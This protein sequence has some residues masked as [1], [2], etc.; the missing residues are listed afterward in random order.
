MTKVLLLVF[1]ASAGFAQTPIPDHGGYWVHD[2]AH[3]LSR[4]TK[5][6]LEAAFKAE[7][8]STSNQIAVIT[9][10]SLENDDISNYA[11]NVFQK[12]KI[13]Q[14]KKDNGVLFVIAPN[15]RKVRIEVGYGLE[16][17]LT[18][19]LSSRIIRN[20]VAPFFRSDNFDAGVKAGALSIIKAL[21]GQYKPDATAFRFSPLIILFII[22]LIFILLP[23]RG[24]RNGKYRGGW[25][26]PIFMAGGLP[27]SMMGGSSWT[28][29]SFSGGSWG[30]G[31]MSGGGGASGSW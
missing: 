24:G 5:S 18:D 19:A 25:A 17:V 13:G 9:V 31:G 28:G 27:R 6:E 10:P 3:I 7:R 11:V 22:I 26:T 21:E 30:G 14:T 1:I 20:E 2:E 12:W 4:Q 16:G 23:R 15:E 29:G 8:D